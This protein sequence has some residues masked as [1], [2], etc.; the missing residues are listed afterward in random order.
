MKMRNQ[1]TEKTAV[2]TGVTSGIGYEIAKR[3]AQEGAYLIC[4]SR[5]SDKLPQIKKELSALTSKIEFLYADLAN[6]DSVNDLFEELNQIVPKVDIL[7]N[8]A[9]FGISGEYINNSMSDI[10]AM[11]YVNMISLAKLTHWCAN[12]MKMQKS[13]YILNISAV[14]A[15]QPQP[16]F[17]IFGATRSFI[18]NLTVALYEELKPYN[19]VVSCAH[20]GSTQSNFEQKAQI[21]HTR[22]VKMLGYMRADFVAKKAIKG[23]KKHKPFVVIGF[24]YKLIYYSSLI[25]PR[26]LGLKLMKFL[27]K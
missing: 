17:G 7:V 1:F 20:P 19:I 14:A 9:G 12:K 15:F 3:L 23:L 2:I 4:I 16:F 25:T 22:A 10:E 26:K 18:T 5:N 11:C 24:P 6:P 8:N 21:G 13:G 27:F